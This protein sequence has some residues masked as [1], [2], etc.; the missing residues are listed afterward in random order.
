MFR[1]FRA[2]GPQVLSNSSEEHLFNPVALNCPMLAHRGLDGLSLFPW[3]GAIT[4]LNAAGQFIARIFFEN[5]ESQS[6][7]NMISYVYN[8]MTTAGLQL[9]I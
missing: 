1:K 4:S 5:S 9:N 3:Q 7:N 6:C 2:L 8:Y